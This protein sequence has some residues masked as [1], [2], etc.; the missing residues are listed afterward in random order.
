MQFLAFHFKTD[1]EI[2]FLCYSEEV[3]KDGSKQIQ[4]VQDFNGI[5]LIT[6]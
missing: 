4:H 5:Q 2:N 1:I 6:F 3:L